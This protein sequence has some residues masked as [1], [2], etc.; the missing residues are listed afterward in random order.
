MTPHARP[1]ALALA[2]AAAPA[3]AVKE[4]RLIHVDTYCSLGV[5]KTPEIPNNTASTCFATAMLPGQRIPGNYMLEDTHR[6]AY[7]SCGMSVAHATWSGHASRIVRGMNAPRDNAAVLADFTRLRSLHARLTADFKC[8]D[9]SLNANQKLPP[10]LLERLHQQARRD[11]IRVTME[12]LDKIT[13]KTPADA[14][15]N[16][17]D[18]LAA[19]ETGA[20]A[21][22][23]ELA[24]EGAEIR[25][26]YVQ[27][28]RANSR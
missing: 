22:Q 6:P 18:A 3:H 5:G 16:I 7:C 19:V 10:A 11:Y 25:K 23:S 13:L 9:P 15:R 4:I 28:G 20:E 24:E 14:F 12:F 27:S 26:A 2:A 8:P 21:C 1:F 17:V